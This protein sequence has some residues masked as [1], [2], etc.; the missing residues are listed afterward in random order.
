ME[1]FNHLVQNHL[2]NIKLDIS[3]A[4]YSKV[5]EHWSKHNFIDDFNR[6]YLIEAG[7]GW[8]KIGEQEYYPKPGQLFLLPAGVQESYSV[9]SANTFSKYWCH[10]NATIGDMHLFQMLE[11]PHFIDVPDVPGLIELFKKL[12]H[13]YQTKQITSLLRMKSL[14]TECICFYIENAGVQNIRFESSAAEKVNVV[15]KYIEQHLSK[16]IKIEELAKL[17][18]LHPNYFIRFFKSALGSSPILY[19][20]K[21]KIEKAKHLILSSDKSVAQIADS[22][23]L[24]PH[25]FSR[26]FKEMT[27]FSPSDFRHVVNH[28]NE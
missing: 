6:F 11:V 3:V 27:G 7:E 14:L 26:L 18:H 10:F 16:E 5:N 8:V 21:L 22:I 1:T 23:G 9:I 13:Y 2:S 20:N 4:A 25:Y 15:L 19:I 24:Q 28:Q 17:V 12:I